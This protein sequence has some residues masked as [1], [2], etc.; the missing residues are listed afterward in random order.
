MWNQIALVV[1]DDL[2]DAVIGELTENGVAGV[3]E[4]A[5]DLPGSTRLVAY[6]GAPFNIDNLEQQIHDIFDRDSRGA[7]TISRAVVEQC[8]WTEEWRKSYT[9]FPI[10]NNFF[11][12]PSW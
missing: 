12:I 1:P 11:V 6:F 8:D 4:D 9:S 7:P 5:S 3:W 10:G 2:K